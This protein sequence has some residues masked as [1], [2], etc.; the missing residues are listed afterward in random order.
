MFNVSHTGAAQVLTSSHN[1][2]PLESLWGT[3]EWSI[4]MWVYYTG[5]QTPEGLSPVFQ[6]APRPSSVCGSAAIG[7]GAAL[8]RGAV[9][10]YECDMGFN[11]EASV[12]VEVPGFGAAPR[13]FKWYHIAVTYTAT[14][15]PP[16]LTQSLYI[17]GVLNGE[18]NVSLDV[19]R[20]DPRLGE[21][22]DVGGGSFALS[23]IRAHRGVLTANN[24]KYNFDQELGTYY[25][26][27]T[28]THT[29]A[30]SHTR[31]PV[32]HSRA[33]CVAADYSQRL[34]VMYSHLVQLACGSIF[35]HPCPSHYSTQ[36]A[37]RREDARSEPHAH[38]DATGHTFTVR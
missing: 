21:W 31:T 15:A 28:R 22:T 37:Y 8:N 19:A 6:W 24:I 16:L 7:L 20:A 4:E 17:D 30:P 23:H 13:P 33:P 38:E 36:V 26:S 10:N 25:P 34:S 3:H 2:L 18:R 32:S 29:R 14:A 27:H 9:S 12:T 11:P 35:V 5:Y 1:A